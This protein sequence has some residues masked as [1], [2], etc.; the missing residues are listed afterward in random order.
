VAAKPRH[1]ST[2]LRCTPSQWNPRG[3]R[4]SVRLLRI[5]IVGSDR[6]LLWENLPVLSR[7]VGRKDR[8]V[9]HFS[10]STL[11]FA[12]VLAASSAQSLS[13]SPSNFLFGDAYVIGCAFPSHLLMIAARATG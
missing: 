5:A 2:N 11:A 9:L 7:Y 1:E 4:A 13:A 8:R 6:V 12:W 3:L 10:T